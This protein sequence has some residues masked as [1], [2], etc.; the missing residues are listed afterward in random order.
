MSKAVRSPA[1]A[2]PGAGRP[3]CLSEA[4]SPS[5]GR[6][7]QAVESFFD[8]TPPSRDNDEREQHMAEKKTPHQ[9]TIEQRTEQQQRSQEAELSAH[10]KRELEAYLDQRDKERHHDRGR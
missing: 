2:R 8:D 7:S 4:G 3:I 5:L 6:L 1:N 10:R 9:P